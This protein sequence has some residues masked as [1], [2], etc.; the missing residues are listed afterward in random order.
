MK[1]HILGICG[2]FMS[3]LAIIAKQKGF[4]VSGSDQNLMPNVAEML[5]SFDIE[6]IEGYEKESLPKDVDCVVIGNALSR[7]R[8]VVEH[9]LNQNIPYFSGPEWLLKNV[10][11]DRWVLAVS[12]THGK[13]T[14]TSM[15][16]WILEEAGLN[17]GFLIGGNPCD[18]PYS[19]RYTDSSFFVIEADEYDTAFFDK[20]SKFLHYHPRTLLIN[21][22]E[23]D[24]A[25]IFSS[26]EDIKKQFSHLLRIVPENGLIVAPKDDENVQSLFPRGCWTKIENFGEKD[27]DWQY[28]KIK[29]D[30]SEFE[31]VNN[32][33]VIGKVTWNLLGDHNLK[34]A[35]A[36]IAG[37][38]HAGIPPAIAVNALCR[39][40]GVKRRLELKGI[41]KD[42]HIYDDFAH[43]PTA[44]ATTLSALRSRIGGQR[45]F[46]VLEF[47]SNTMRRGYYNDT[48][49]SAFSAADNIVFLRPKEASWEVEKMIADIK[50]PVS[51]FNDVQEIV[52]YLVQEC[53]GGD[54]ILCMSNLMFDGIHQKLLNKLAE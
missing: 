8:P 13:T 12:G 2:K 24:H 54:H 16:A 4:E 52:N 23:F 51:I 10:L 40:Q 5:R 11:Q 9:I 14:T 50:Q 33:K 20:R 6:L 28:K 29:A 26:L 36:A 45:L 49:S 42:I 25:D 32:E 15:L 3:G 43:H 30:G 47:G 22:L 41:V 46:A 38:R 1:I 31:I 44:I 34:N 35:I 17:P 39:F 19:A 48:M 37:A 7:G 21:N 18:F 27:A 53:H